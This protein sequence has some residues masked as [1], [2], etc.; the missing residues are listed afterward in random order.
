VPF[1]DVA[2]TVVRD[3]AWHQALSATTDTAGATRATGE[4]S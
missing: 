2:V 1:G 4:P 3:R